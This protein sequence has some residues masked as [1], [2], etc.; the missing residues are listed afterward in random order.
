[1]KVRKVEYKD[2]AEEQWEKFQKEMQ[3]ENQVGEK[4]YIKTNWI[5]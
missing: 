1:M 5:V 4:L 3:V 2:Q